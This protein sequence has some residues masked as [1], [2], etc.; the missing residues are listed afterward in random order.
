MQPKTHVA[1]KTAALF[2]A[3][4]YLGKSKKLKGIKKFVKGATREQCCYQIIGDKL[5]IQDEEDNRLSLCTYTKL[6]QDTSL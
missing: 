3:Q 5:Y 4:F 6:C 2:Q 1:T